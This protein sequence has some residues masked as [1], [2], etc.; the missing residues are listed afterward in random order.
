VTIVTVVVTGAAGFVGGV[1]VREL[2][3]RG[4]RVRAVD[5]A[6][7]TALPPEVER[8]EADVLDR[9][10]LR[11]A[12][13]GADVVFH[14]AAVISVTG[15]LGGRVWSVNVDGVRNIA[16]V[17]LESGV[18]R[19][20][21]CSSV[22]AFDLEAR[23]SVDEDSPKAR[24]EHRPIYDRSKAAGEEELHSVIRRGLDAV[25]VNPT[26]VIG[27]FDEGPSRMGQVL[28]A[29]SRRRLPALLDGGFN[30]VDVRDVVS[31]LLA[32]EEKGRAG[33][34]Y[35][36]PG[37]YASIGD[38]ATLVRRVTGTRPPRFTVPL[39]FARVW[40]P[41]ANLVSRSTGSALWYTTESLH[42]LRFCPQISGARARGELGYEPRPL[43]ETVAD[44]LAFFDERGL[45]GP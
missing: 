19:F 32:A 10:S 28:I 40:G 3:A 29:L 16:E 31:G 20:V 17:A 45:L 24:D 33:A 7:P 6:F 4:R 30:W 12:V 18:R 11:V 43:T 21:H 2:V 9:E 37:H 13:D 14:L 25:I 23:P 22:H 1:L 36:L 41:L 44:T 42:A 5:R 27:P 26:G 39:W 8:V 38:L 35:L 34:S 15:G